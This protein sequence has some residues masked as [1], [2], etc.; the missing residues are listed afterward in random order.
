MFIKYYRKMSDVDK[1]IIFKQLTRNVMLWMVL[2]H[3]IVA[4]SLSIMIHNS[5]PSNLR[6]LLATHPVG[7]YFTDCNFLLLRVFFF[8]LSFHGL[9]YMTPYYHL[10]VF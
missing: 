7:T 6:D 2:A 5:I 8:F 4:L 9:R 3:Y 1:A 10:I